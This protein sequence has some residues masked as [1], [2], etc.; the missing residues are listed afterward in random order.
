MARRV[1]EIQLVGFAILGLVVERDALGLDRD[2]PFP[3]EIH[4]IE[5]LGFHFP[6]SQAAAKLDQ[7]VSQGRLPVIDVGDDGKV[8]DSFRCRHDG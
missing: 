4:G 5:H 8:S 3:L 6:L 2:A 7:T 1:D